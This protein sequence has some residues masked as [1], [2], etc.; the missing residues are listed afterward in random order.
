[1]LGAAMLDFKVGASSLVRVG[2]VLP[3]FRVG[4]PTSRGVPNN[5]SD[6]EPCFPVQ[7]KCSIKTRVAR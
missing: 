6:Q 1:M 7:L 5:I 3:N 2:A 4:N